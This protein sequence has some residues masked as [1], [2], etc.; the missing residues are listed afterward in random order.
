MSS[1][2]AL[3]HFYLFCNLLPDKAAQNTVDKFYRLRRLVF[4]GNLHRLV[5]GGAVGDVLHVQNLI[6][7]HPHDGGGF[8]GA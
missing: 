7:G 8:R 3:P 6:H 4:L 5:D 2:P 1:M